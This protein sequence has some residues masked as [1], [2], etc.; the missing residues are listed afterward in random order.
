MSYASCSWPWQGFF[1]SK[2]QTIVS[3][4]SDTDC[5]IPQFRVFSE[6]S[7]HSKSIPYCSCESLK[8][9]ES[10]WDLMSWVVGILW[11]L[12]FVVLEFVFS[13]LLK[14][15]FSFILCFFHGCTVSWNGEETS[16]RWRIFFLIRCHYLYWP[17]FMK[18]A[19]SPKII[20]VQAKTVPFST[21]SYPLTPTKTISSYQNLW[22]PFCQ[23]TYFM[24]LIF[25][26]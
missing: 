6:E 25:T 15:L 24:P 22:M 20:S 7:F 10:F 1:G 12:S 3:S 9:L 21:L 13:T 8:P 16:V 4:C 14:S 17:S 11:C 18:I 2:S 5:S 26:K 23:K 19:P